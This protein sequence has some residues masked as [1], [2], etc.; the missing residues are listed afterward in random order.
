MDS[1]PSEWFVC[2]QEENTLP[3]KQVQCFG[4]FKTALE[5]DDFYKNILP[6]KAKSHT[7][8]TLLWTIAFF[9]KIWKQQHVQYTYS[10]T[11]Q[12]VYRFNNF[13]N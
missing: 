5:A 7:N 1:F 9:P 11:F 4:G 8:S 3:K 2:Y 12:P 6:T 10:K 13:N